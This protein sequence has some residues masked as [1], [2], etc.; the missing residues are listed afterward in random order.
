MRFL[1][2]HSPLV[3]PTAWEWVADALVASGHEA[4][5]PD[6]RPAARA[7]DPAAV[8]GLVDASAGGPVDVIA[9]HSG[10]GY[11]LPAIGAA[12]RSSLRRLVFVDAGIPPCEGTT[13]AGDDFM[14]WIRTLA[15]DGVLPEWSRWWDEDTMRHLVPDADRRERF[16][17]GLPRVPVTF[18]ET[19]VALPDRWCELPGAYLLLS[20]GYRRH[21]VTARARGWPTLALERA[22]LDIVNHPD[23]VVDALV[24][25]ANASD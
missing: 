22:H 19:P 3:G 2:V 6:L 24:Q 4:R 17:A 7:G 20:E 13:D 10:A 8:L 25:L 9:G 16:E 5:V 23:T 21:E 11:F 15:V 18:Y 1:L 14:G 12:N